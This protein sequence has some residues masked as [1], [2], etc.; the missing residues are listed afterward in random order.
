MESERPPELEAAALEEYEFLLE[1]QAFPFE[2]QAIEI[3][4][5]NASRA[6]HGEY[7]DWVEASY[8]ELAALVPGRYARNE[9][10]ADVVRL[11]L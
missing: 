8:R 9:R 7:D 1:E 5:A 10:G 2:E 3:H 4:E 6:R 11:V